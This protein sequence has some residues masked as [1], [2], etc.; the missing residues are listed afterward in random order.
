M[1]RAATCCVA[2][3]LFVGGGSAGGARER[4]APRGVVYVAATLAYEQSTA[5]GSGVAVGSRSVLTSDHV[6]RG[7]TRL[8]VTDA[9]S[10]RTYTA[11]VVGYDTRADVA[12]LRVRATRPL[13]AAVL[14]GGARLAAGSAVAAVGYASVT[15]GRVTALH[16]SVRAIDAD[17]TVEQLTGLIET[18][19]PPPRGTSGGPLVDASGRVVGIDAAAWGGAAGGRGFAVPIATALAVVHRIESGHSGG[20]THVGP[21]PFLGVGVAAAAAYANV[22]STRGA[23]VAVVVP[24]SPAARAGVANGDVITSIDGR[25]VAAPASLANLIL[26]YGSAG[27]TVRVG[28]VD[29]YGLVH[30]ATVRLASGP[31]Q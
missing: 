15:R 24:A 7:A 13:R 19:A 25:A 11:V 18:D 21:T 31:P 4:G 2:L 29:R 1:C 27:G 5:A 14:G 12:L 10:G 9:R 28:W 17:G 26:R 3:A 8:R 30:R 20:T 22:T 6:V 16:E 23:L